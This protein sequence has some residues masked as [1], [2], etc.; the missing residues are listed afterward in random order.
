MICHIDEIVAAARAGRPVIMIDAET[1]KN[2]GHLIVPAQFADAATINFM[3]RHCRGI[4]ALAITAERARALGLKPMVRWNESHYQMAYTVSIEARS[5]VS[6]GISAGDRA[7]TIRTA[8][9]PH[10]GALDIVTPGH[11]FPIIASE[12]GLTARPGHTEAAIEICQRAGLIPA[13]VVC[14]IMGVDGSMATRAE[15]AGLAAAHDLPVGL[16]GDLMAPRPAMTRL[17]EAAILP[18]NAA[19]RGGMRHAAAG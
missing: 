9:D 7:Q 17:A 19:Q 3:A 2:E 12:G 10:S 11:V 13:A 5:G 14:A 16:V 8:I 6:T 18:F 4:V 1:R 15:L